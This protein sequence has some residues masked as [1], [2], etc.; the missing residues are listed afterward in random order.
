MENEVLPGEWVVLLAENVEKMNRL[1]ESTGVPS[2]SFIDHISE[3]IGA[4]G[5]VYDVHGETGYVSVQFHVNPTT[6]YRG[7][8]FSMHSDWLK[9]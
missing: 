9:D 4:E 2:R 3:Y 1:N 5:T 6:G 8:S 7:W